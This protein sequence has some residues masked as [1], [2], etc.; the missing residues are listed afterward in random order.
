[1]TFEAPPSSDSAQ[2][3]QDRKPPARRT[4]ASKRIA[5]L[6]NIDFEDAR[7]DND[8]AWASR[9]EV[10]TVANAVA[11]ALSDGGYD[12]H[13]VPVDG[14]LASVRARL[15]ELD[16]TCAF[17]LCE[18]LGG[19][20]RL[21]SAVPLVLELLGVPFTGSPPEVLSF[22]LRKDRVKQ[23]LEAAGIPT[24]A[25]RVLARPDDPCD[26]P[27]PLIAKPVREDG[28][29]GI[30][31]GSVVWEPAQLGPAVEAVL[32]TFRQPCLVEQFIDGRELNVALL[33]H[34]TPRVLPLSE[35][36]FTGL[37]DEAPRIVSYEAKWASGS[38]DD[39]GTVPVLHPTLPNNVAARVRRVA[40]EAFRAVGVRDYG[41]VDVRLGVNG[42]PYVIDVNPNCDLARHAGMARAAAAVGI[43]YG[44]FVALLVRYALR[45][46]RAAETGETQSP[47]RSASQRPLY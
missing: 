15:A 9:A 45:R 33:G 41:R 42:V 8:P 38:V 20:A 11:A 23:R 6:Y 37:P 18:S 30:N 14:D 44:A 39:L 35:I 17:N 36:D 21:E 27:F 12:T 46:R 13:L 19:D 25:G 34:P 4:R 31:R 2:D 10:E 40:T 1:M 32:T 26:L 28:S 7:P 29:V 47:Q 3:P 43:D 24:P 22:A 16:P 5:V